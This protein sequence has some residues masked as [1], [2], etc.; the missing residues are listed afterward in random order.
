MPYSDTSGSSAGDTSRVTTFDSSQQTDE[1]H[2]EFWGRA[3][4]AMRSVET[5]EIVDVQ[6][7]IV[8]EEESFELTDI[9][10]A[11]AQRH[12]DDVAFGEDDACIL[13]CY[14]STSRYVP[15]RNLKEDLPYDWDQV[16]ARFNGDRLSNLVRHHLQDPKTQNLVLP[17]A[18]GGTSKLRDNITGVTCISHEIDEG[19]DL[20]GQK[21]AWN[22]ANLPEPTISVFTGYGAST[23]VGYSEHRFL[24]LLLNSVT[25]D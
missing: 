22:K 19:L 17:P 4:E 21:V 3:I 6:V 25:S 15:A 1:E 9:D 24:F 2:G 5:S 14:G 12:L 23:T 10:N 11:E 18:L 16:V 7:S 20:E 13:A 8:L